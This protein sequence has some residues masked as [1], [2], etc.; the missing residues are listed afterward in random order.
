MTIEISDLRQC[1]SAAG[2]SMLRTERRNIHETRFYQGGGNDTQD[3]G[4]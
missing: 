4:G 2:F 3:Q 1:A